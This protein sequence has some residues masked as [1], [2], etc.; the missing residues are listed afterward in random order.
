MGPSSTVTDNDR[1]ASTQHLI[2]NSL[3]KR[4]LQIVDL[5][6]NGLQNKEIARELKLSSGTIKVHLHN[7]FTKLAVNNRAALVRLATSSREVMG[8]ALFVLI[9]F[10]KLI[11]A[12]LL[13]NFGELLG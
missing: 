6:S 13:N 5:V 10:S 8:A 4:E 12:A 9:K 7:I 2:P 1:T 3:T 11:A